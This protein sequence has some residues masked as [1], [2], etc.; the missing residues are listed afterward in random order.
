MIAE[1]SVTDRLDP[2][3]VVE[4]GQVRDEALEDE[5]PA[6]IEHA[7]H[8]A[9]VLRLPRLAEQA[10]QRV[11]HQVHQP[12]PAADRHLGHVSQGD[13]D[14]LTARLGPHPFHH[15]ADAST[16]STVIPRAASGS[17]TRPVPMASSSARPSAARPARSSTAGPG[18]ICPWWSS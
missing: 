18:S 12:E 15:P 14:R 2:L 5:H 6:R 8:V 16:P 7:R 9:E 17:A 3:V 10:E 13:R 11:E 1:S 4:P